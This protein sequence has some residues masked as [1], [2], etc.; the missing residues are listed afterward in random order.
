MPLPML[1][2]PTFNVFL[3]SIE[4][5]V[6][7][8]PFIVKEEKL[9]LIAMESNDFNTILNSIK[10]VI[11]NCIITEGV[12]VE[13]LPLHELEYFFLNL[14]SRSMGEKV[15]LEYV[16]EN[17]VDQKKC[18][19]QVF[20]E[21]DLLKVELEE[22][23][24]KTN[25]QLTENVGIKLKYPTIDVSGISN[26]KDNDVD[27]AIELIEKCTEYLYDKEQVYKPSEMAD[28]EF[29]EF[30][31]NLT[32]PQFIMLRDFF[33]DVPKIKYDTTATCRKCKMDHKIHLEGLLDFFV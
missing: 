10:Q 24:L 1:D 2:L 26:D 32:Q 9:L 25:I 17:V 29:K 4:K 14:R 7:F 22:K 19:G 5:E 6:K 18:K 8:R 21:V 20:V 11:Q 31:S 33:E 16:C 27:T 3:P 30:I 15:E 12:S 13:K 23:K 28:G